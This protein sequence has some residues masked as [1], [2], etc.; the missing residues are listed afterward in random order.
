MSFHRHRR[1][2]S[3]HARRH[4]RRLLTEGWVLQVNPGSVTLERPGLDDS[5]FEARGRT[6]P[7][8]V[9]VAMGRAKA[10]SFWVPGEMS[11]AVFLDEGRPSVPMCRAERR[12]MAASRRS[13]LASRAREEAQARADG[14]PGHTRR[15]GWVRLPAA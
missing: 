15:G 10:A 6:V 14:S 5:H 4:L 12:M 1:T 13:W 8:A 9:A 7:Q 2:L 3:P 11:G